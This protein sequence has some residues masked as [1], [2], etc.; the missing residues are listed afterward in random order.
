M[1]SRTGLVRRPLDLLAFTQPSQIAKPED[2]INRF[3]KA[4][5]DVTDQATATF[6]REREKLIAIACQVVESRA[7]AEELVQ[8]SW[9]R[10]HEKDYPSAEALPVFRQIVVNLARDWTRR[11]RKEHS[12]LTELFF[13][14]DSASPCSERVL[15]AR[16]DLKQVIALLSQLPRRS[17]TAFRMH[18]VDGRTYRE[19]GEHLGISVTRA[20]ELVEDTLV[21]LTIH[22]NR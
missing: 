20:Y 11:R 22:L 15:L 18:L 14:T 19:I 10:W 8:D 12:L 21:H 6:I 16:Q 9:L 3:V 2:D 7:I 13:D 5:R 4:T 1:R 17:V